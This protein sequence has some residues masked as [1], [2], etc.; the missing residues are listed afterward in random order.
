MGL[1]C[2]ASS[3]LSSRVWLL[4]LM[5][6][7]VVLFRD[8]HCSFFA[9]TDTYVFLLFSVYLHGLLVGSFALLGVEISQTIR[10]G[11]IE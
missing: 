4:D 10:G 11:S 9:Y 3:S 5:L 6:V 2:R 8:L 7:F 1:R